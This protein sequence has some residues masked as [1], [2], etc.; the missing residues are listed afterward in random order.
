MQTCIENELFRKEFRQLQKVSENCD[1]NDINEL[2]YVCEHC[3][4]SFRQKKYLSQH[5]TKLH[6]NPRNNDIIKEENE[7]QVT[8]EYSLQDNK[9]YILRNTLNEL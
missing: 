8:N 9:R 2:K 7:D 1:S 6:S 4:K 5:V 3:N